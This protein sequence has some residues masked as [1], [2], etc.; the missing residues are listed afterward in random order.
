MSGACDLATSGEPLAFSWSSDSVV[1]STPQ[2]ES[3]P[4]PVPPNR[5][6]I[7]A[8]GEHCVCCLW[9]GCDNTLPPLGTAPGGSGQQQQSPQFQPA[10]SS[11]PIH[12]AG[13]TGT[14]EG[15]S[16]GV[17]EPP[18]LSEE[19]R[20]DPL[21]S[22]LSDC[23]LE[24]AETQVIAGPPSLAKKKTFTKGTVSQGMW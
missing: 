7:D 4:C 24:L 10:N 8:S 9:A 21:W 23:L 1:A 20:L 14:E 19:L 17:E 18:P 13:T 2:A 16:S 11:T 6:D 22:T 3:S 12:P 5:M 15:P